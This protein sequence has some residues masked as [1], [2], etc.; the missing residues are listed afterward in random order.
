[1]LAPKYITPEVFF[2]RKNKK[3]GDK[4]TISLDFVYWRNF[5]RYLDSGLTGTEFQN[6]GLGTN[7]GWCN[8][9]YISY[10]IATPYQRVTGET[11]PRWIG[12]KKVSGAAFLPLAADANCTPNVQTDVLGNVFIRARHLG[13]TNV[14]RSDTSVYS[15][16]TLGRS[17]NDPKL[18]C[19]QDNAGA[20]QIHYEGNR[21]RLKGK[22]HP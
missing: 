14:V 22:Y 5:A 21:E 12:G 15:V 4:T 11:I 20:Y 19:T 3:F 7:P 10:H 2:C 6:R 18:Y 1:M 8:N 16:Q 17:V 9:R 13:T